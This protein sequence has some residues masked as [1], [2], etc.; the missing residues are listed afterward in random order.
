MEEAAA[1]LNSLNTSCEI[2][3]AKLWLDIEKA[4][5]ETLALQTMYDTGEE[6][7]NVLVMKQR[8]IL[9][10]KVDETLAA[11]WKQWSAQAAELQVLWADAENRRKEGKG[12][13]KMDD[14]NIQMIREDLTEDFHA[15]ADAHTKAIG[16]LLEEFN[17]DQMLLMIETEQALNENAPQQPAAVEDRPIKPDSHTPTS[18]RSP[19]ND[20]KELATDNSAKNINAPRPDPATIPKHET[21]EPNQTEGVLHILTKD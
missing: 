18:L 3:T 11:G 15:L 7:I 4:K 8:Q 17:D 21:T 14:N 13:Y 12:F 10:R 6:R 1:R 9:N 5:H 20:K 19:S 16:T 2:L